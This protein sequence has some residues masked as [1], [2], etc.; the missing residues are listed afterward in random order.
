MSDNP[1]IMDDD[2]VLRAAA[3]ATATVNGTGKAIGPTGLC[4]A[5]VIV[6]ALA[7]GGTLAISIQQSSDDA[8]ADAYATI[9]S[10]PTI[11]ATGIYELYFKAT[12]KYVRYSTTAVHGTESITYGVYVT[13]VEK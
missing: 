10:F 6:S 4:K 11:S 3:A 5:I 2:L 13:T 8:S 12:E 7:A 9:A 1:I